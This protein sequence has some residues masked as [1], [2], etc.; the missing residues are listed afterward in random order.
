MMY[1]LEQAFP[2]PTNLLLR[3]SKQIQTFVSDL[4]KYK[5]YYPKEILA[6]LFVYEIA[7]EEYIQTGNTLV[8]VIGGVDADTPMVQ[9]LEL[10]D[11]FRELYDLCDEFNVPKTMMVQIESFFLPIIDTWLLRTD[12]K[13][14]EWVVRAYAVDSF[15]PMSTP[16]RLNS[17]SVL[18][19]FSA[20]QSALTFVSKFRFNDPEKREMLKRSFIMAMHKS[21]D[22]YCKMVFA[23]FEA[24]EKPDDVTIITPQVSSYFFALSYI[25]IIFTFSLHP[26]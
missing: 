7:G 23:D 13:W 9:I 12:S 21:L 11:L 14:V 19:I 4:R 16:K 5:V 8:E 2:G 17:T 20:F 18:D 22:T 25:S 24:M 1:K 15:E 3:T 26:Y 10:Y 6:S